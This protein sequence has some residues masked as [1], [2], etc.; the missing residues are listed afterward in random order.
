MVFDVSSNSYPVYIKD[1]LVNSNDDFDY[2]AFRDLKELAT[3]SSLSVSSFAF[4]FTTAGNYVFQLSDNE[5]MVTIISV[6]D[7]ELTC[8]TDGVFDIMSSGTLVDVTAMGL[9]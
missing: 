8:A 4:T 2:S 3:S 1:S 9:I 5:D 6:V 7:S